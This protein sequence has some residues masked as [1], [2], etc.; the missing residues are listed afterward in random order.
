MGKR[1]A[2]SVFLL[3][4]V[5]LAG[6]VF[7]GETL[8]EVKK[9]G[10]LVAGVKDSSPPFGFRD[11]ATGELVGID[12]EIA[13][14][15]AKSLGVAFEAVPV[16]S[17]SRIPD[18]LDGKIDLIAATMSRTSDRDLLIDFSRT[19]FRTAQRVLA[20]KGSVSS[21]QDLGGKKVGT[22]KGSTS[23]KNLADQVPGAKVV[24]FEHYGQV[25]EALEKGQ[26]DAAS[27]DG[28]LLFAMMAGLPKDAYEIAPMILSEEEYGLGVRQG[29][30]KFLAAV[31]RA[32]DELKKS[33]ELMR[34]FEKWIGGQPGAAPV[35]AA[36]PKPAERK[37]VA[38]AA[39]VVARQTSA[40]GRFV[41][42]PMK[43]IFREGAPVAVFTPQGDP[44]GKGKVHSVYADRVYVD[45]DDP[46]APVT[47]GYP[48]GM[49]VADK[50]AARKLI[51]DRQE[52][53]GSVKGEIE[54]VQEARREE[55]AREQKKEW[56]DRAK[57]QEEMTKKAREQSYQYDYYW[58]DRP[59]YR[60]YYW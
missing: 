7:A 13:R 37:P 19:Y 23:E 47:L 54:K 38:E 49:N 41:V 33:G 11:K 60:S 15:A 42:V 51:E 27:T 56:D 46:A 36:P 52:V 1:T 4:F 44:V 5:F 43:G 25:K 14:A 31:D 9:K 21:F 6:A 50:E 26:I 53:L 28:I 45:M 10:V 32:L 57:Y 55:V 34:I 3:A 17:V 8:D 22:G 24:T 39:G 20:K 12:V 40:P 35:A 59:Y 48:V 18:L 58:Y 30:P 16:T 29:S 2:I